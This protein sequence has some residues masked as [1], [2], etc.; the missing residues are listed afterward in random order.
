MTIAKIRWT[1]GVLIIS[2]L[3]MVEVYRS[4]RVDHHAF[5]NHVLG[6][7]G[8]GL[9]LIALFLVGMSWR[10]PSCL[11]YTIIFGKHCIRCGA[12]LDSES[13]GIWK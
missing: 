10:C 11:K 3:V 8:F 4:V 5:A 7:I 2:Y 13:Q 12:R 1:T 9:G 6:P